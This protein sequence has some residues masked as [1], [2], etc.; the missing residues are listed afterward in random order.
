MAHAG[1]PNCRNRNSSRFSAMDLSQKEH[2]QTSN[3]I[4]ITTAITKRSSPNS[5]LDGRCFLSVQKKKNSSSKKGLWAAVHHQA[6]QTA[7]NAKTHGQER[8]TAGWAPVWESPPAGR[9]KPFFTISLPNKKKETC[10]PGTVQC[11][12]KMTQDT[13]VTSS[14]RFSVRRQVT[15]RLLVASQRRPPQ[16]SG[17]QWGWRLRP[18]PLAVFGGTFCLEKNSNKPRNL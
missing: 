5:W 13:L 7:E 16:A 9:F 3:K 8:Q 2:L 12:K 14:V 10:W 1:L 18:W 15:S 11:E 4:K 6:P 17:P